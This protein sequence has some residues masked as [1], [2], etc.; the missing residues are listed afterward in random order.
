MKFSKNTQKINP[1]KVSSLKVSKD[2]IWNKINAI[3]FP[4]MLIEVL[5]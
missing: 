4:E 3:Q 5:A 1:A 2:F